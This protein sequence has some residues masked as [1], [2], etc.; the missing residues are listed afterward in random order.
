[1][2]RNEMLNAFTNWMSDLFSLVATE[3]CYKSLFKAGIFLCVSLFASGQVVFLTALPY[4][5]EA[6]SLMYKV[7]SESK[8]KVEHKTPKDLKC[9][10]EMSSQ[11][12]I[13]C[14]NS[15]YLYDLSSSML[16]VFEVWS[17]LLGYLMY[18]LFVVS[19]AGFI[20]RNPNDNNAS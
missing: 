20:I 11:V 17:K 16:S 18:F 19:V 12:Y 7:E 10:L 8:V 6:I 2:L 13:D 3:K 5:K 14:K 1:M 15:R 9:S 4:E